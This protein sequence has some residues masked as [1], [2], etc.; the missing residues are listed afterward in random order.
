MKLITS[1]ICPILAFEY[2]LSFGCLILKVRIKINCDRLKLKNSKTELMPYL[3]EIL[4]VTCLFIYYP[5]NFMEDNGGTHR[6]GLKGVNVS[7]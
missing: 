5:R 6:D 1:Y 4:G 2:T 7:T 3:F